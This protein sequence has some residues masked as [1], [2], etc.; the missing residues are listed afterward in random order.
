MQLI[1]IKNLTAVDEMM[2]TRRD[3]SMKSEEIALSVMSTFSED[4]FE[5]NGLGERYFYK[6]NQRKE[7]LHQ[8]K[9]HLGRPKFGNKWENLF[10]LNRI[11]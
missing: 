11:I 6:M 8:V 3:H 2:A 9:I 7:T 4:D 5:E 1:S 10:L